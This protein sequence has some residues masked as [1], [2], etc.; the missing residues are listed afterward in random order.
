[1]HLEHVMENLDS[2]D[3]VDPLAAGGTRGRE[4]ERACGL[5]RERE[6]PVLSKRYKTGVSSGAEGYA[7][8]LFGRMGRVIRNH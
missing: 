6:K 5:T 7:R 1:M 2:D 8:V 3:E 4:R